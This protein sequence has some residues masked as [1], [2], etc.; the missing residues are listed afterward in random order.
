MDIINFIDDYI[1]KCYK[2]NS[3]EGILGTTEAEKL[4]SEIIGVFGNSISNIWDGLSR[5]AMYYD[6]E[7][8]YK[9]NIDILL[10]KLELLKISI[11]NEKE[12]RIHDLRLAELQQSKISTQAISNPVQTSTQTQNQSVKVELSID[13]MFANIDSIPNNELSEDDK[14]QLK[15]CI[16]SLEGAKAIQDKSV[17]WDKAKVV[18]KFL[19]D[20][21][22]DAAVAVLPYLVFG[23]SNA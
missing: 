16:M 17:F 13:Q 20:K 3:R 21:G 19:A 22:M 8:D 12:K 23:L 6:D 2:V 5:K 7:P 10:K 14:K 11:E 9:T 18:L 4:Q 1:L 15:E